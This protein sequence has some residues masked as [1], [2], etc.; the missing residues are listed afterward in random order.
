M[1]RFFRLLGLA[2]LLVLMVAIGYVVVTFPPIMAGMAAK[3]ICSCVFVS[4]RTPQSVRDKELKVFPGLSSASID[5]NEQEQSVEAHI[6]WRTSKAIF[7]NGL[8]CTLL[9]ER[10]E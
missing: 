7:R 1:K 2:L 9:A 5:V 3:T 10:S 6:L 8:G 4:G